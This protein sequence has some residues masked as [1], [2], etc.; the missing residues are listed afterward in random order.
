MT[1]Y[2]VNGFGLGTGPARFASIAEV[3]RA[4]EDAG[5]TA[6]WT[7]ELY[8]RSAT[9]PMAVIAGATSR[10]SVGSN[11]AY[12][13]GR[14]PLMW[15]AEARDLDE[16]SGGRLILGLGNGTPAM[17]ERWH[18]V[19]GEAPAAR[20]RELVAVLR[21]LWRLDQGPVDHD[22]RFYTAH[23]APTTAMAPPLREHL[24]IY[25]AGVNPAMVRIAGEVADGLVGHPMFTSDYLEAVVRPALVRGA[26]SAGRSAADIAVTG[27]KMCVIDD[28]EESAR[29][30]AAF[31]IGQYAASRVYDRLF[32]LHGWAEAQQRI[33]Q[34]ARDRYGEALIRAVPDDAVDAV[35]V[36]CTPDQFGARL[37]AA[38]T[39]FDHLALTPAPWG[40]NDEQTHEATWR[41]IT[42]LRSILTAT[43]PALEHSR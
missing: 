5:C 34:A 16:L 24:P 25:L 10:V 22:G 23:V 18:G 33:R 21:K 12:G 30:Q 38:S 27:I 2:G 17:M 14:T 9:V 15:V 8:S 43:D 1:T 20:M 28:D 6:V 3:A 42:S 36:A 41:I 39:G 29:R 40:L 31:A 7:S 35:A 11:I 4:A 26:S 13:V 32:E 19:S 37:R